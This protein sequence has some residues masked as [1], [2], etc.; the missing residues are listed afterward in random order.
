[1]VWSWLNLGVL[2]GCL[3]T[4][5][6]NAIFE[7]AQKFNHLIT[8]IQR[9]ICLMSILHALSNTI[10][11]EPFSYLLQGRRVKNRMVNI[12]RENQMFC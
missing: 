4:L 11:V 5:A 7:F 9:D 10:E 12:V 6:W 2:N 1:M 8:N 3:A